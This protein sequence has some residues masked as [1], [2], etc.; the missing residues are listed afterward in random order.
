MRRIAA[1]LAVAFLA[2][3]AS[4]D[5][6]DEHYAQ[7]NNKEKKFTLHQQVSGCSMIINYEVRD[8]WV[9][10]AAIKVAIMR[11]PRP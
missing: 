2:V 11:V 4:A 8:V 10:L 3:P 6:R 1:L 7:C 9:Q 5:H